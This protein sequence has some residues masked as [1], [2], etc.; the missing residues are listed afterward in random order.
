MSGTRL[1]PQWGFIP[2]SCD[3]LSID[4]VRGT[5]APTLVGASENSRH[6]RQPYDLDKPD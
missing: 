3:S 6:S 5:A 1:A 2:A 4:R